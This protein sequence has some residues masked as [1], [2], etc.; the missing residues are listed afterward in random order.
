MKRKVLS[1][2]LAASMMGSML[3]GCGSAETNSTADAGTKDEAGVTDQAST[4]NSDQ[5]GDQADGENITLKWAI[6]DQ[7]TT[8]YW[9]A[10]KT[11]YE[12]A[13]PNVT[14]EMVDLGS[15]D[16]M[17]VLATELSGSDTDFDVVTIKDV[18]GYATLVQKNTLEPLD[19]YI[20]DAG[21][22]LADFNGVTDQV[23]VDGSLYELPFRSDFWL[24]F[25]NK[26]VFD[27]AGVDYPSNDMTVEEYDA[28]ARQLTDTTYG[29]QVYGCHYHTW[30]SAVELFGTLDGK[31]SIL[32]GNYDWMTPYYDMVLSEEDDGVCQ[33]YTD[34]S[35]EG[36]H[37]SAAFSN[38]NVAMLNMGSWFI[39]TMISNLE[40]GEYD[41]SVCGNWGIA[42][43]PHPDGAEAGSTIATITGL[44]VTSASANKDAA[45]DFVNF[46]SGDEGANVMAKTGNFPAK[47][48]DDV[49][50]IIAGMQGF[51]AD[52][53]S[54]Q[55]LN[56]SNAYLEVPYAENVSEINSILDTYHTAIM[57]REVTVEEGIASMNSE[58]GKILGK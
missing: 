53:N 10:L 38:G 11:A 12:A 54:K 57:N 47:M 45:F 28:L 9:D 55:A 36:L 30:R 2:I 35:T 13:N 1:M 39:A 32:D 19:G 21:I 43:Y 37:Y 18:P 48:T 5:T 34:L 40:S 44:A 14:I 15:A 31:H 16:Y 33:S 41:S 52:E 27:A 42:S 4:Q 6:W 22:D 46:V 23:T 7:E 17:T 24:I 49:I 20:K 3:A 8:P 56:I 51:P 50:D 25:Y 26:D 29:S 58:V